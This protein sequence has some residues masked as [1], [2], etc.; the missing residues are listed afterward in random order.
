MFEGILGKDTKCLGMPL[1]C[2]LI[3]LALLYVISPVD[4]LPEIFLGPIGLIDDAIALFMAF[5][6]GSKDIF[7]KLGGM[8]K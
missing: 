7:G 1:K 8:F 4:F 5:G 3:G 6:L 2:L